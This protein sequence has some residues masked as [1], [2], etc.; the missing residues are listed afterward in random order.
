MIIK[1]YC[2]EFLIAQNFQKTPKF[3]H[4]IINLARLKFQDAVHFRNR[5]RC[6]DHNLGTIFESF[7][8]QNHH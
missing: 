6:D 5:H 8:K 2:S 7:Y 3:N 4:L 1:I